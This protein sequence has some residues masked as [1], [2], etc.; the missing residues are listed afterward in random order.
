MRPGITI[1]LV[2]ST[3]VAPRGTGTS[4]RAP[5]ATTRPP[6]TTS[7]A[8][9]LTGPP[10]PPLPPPP[11]H[12]TPP[13][14]PPARAR[15]APPRPRGDTPSPLD[16]ERGIL[17]HRAARAVDQPRA[18][19]RRGRGTLRLSRAGHHTED[20]KDRQPAHGY[21]R[22]GLRSVGPNRRDTTPVA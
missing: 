22:E 7:A 5:A 21:L 3:T 6:W 2:R 12:P 11:P 20:G 10:P 16:H 17:D 1:L 13:R 14:P 8:S 4:L 15:P 18:D 19:E 9:S